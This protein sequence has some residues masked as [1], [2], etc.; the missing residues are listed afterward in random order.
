MYMIKY[1]FTGFL[2]LMASAG[3]SQRAGKMT[4]EEYIERYKDL[5]VKQMKESGIPASITLAQG[6]LESGNGNSRLSV[7]GNNHFGIKCHSSWTGEYI[8]HDDD[9]LQECFRKYTSVEGSYND[10]SDFLRYRDRYKFLFDL[11]P[12]DYK[13]WAHGLKKAGY[14]T[15]PQYAEQLIKIIED[16]RLYQ[17]DTGT[18]VDVPPPSTIEQPKRVDASG[19]R[20]LVIINRDLFERNGAMYVLARTNDTYELI[21]NEYNIKLKRLLAYNDEPTNHLL[22]KGQVVYLSKKQSK[23]NKLQP[24]HIANDNETLWQIA[25]R[26]AVRLKSIEKYNNMQ[27]GRQ[28][29]EG[30]EIYLRNKMRK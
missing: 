21:A 9:A 28:P 10:H 11:P 6:C 14:A 23:A 25:Q 13:A 15:N 4:R 12:T 26:Y 16:Y 27:D 18:P 3:F 20:H 2:L 30:Q 5:A 22:E 19:K 7:E 1:L 24:V 29:E 17:Y 8:H